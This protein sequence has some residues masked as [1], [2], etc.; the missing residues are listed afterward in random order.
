MRPSK[1]NAMPAENPRDNPVHYPADR[2]LRVWVQPRVVV[3]ALVLV[4]IPVAA[5]WVQVLAVG[6]PEIASSPPDHSAFDRPS[7][8]PSWVRVTHYVHFL[9]LVLLVRSGLSILMDH[10]RLYWNDHCTPGTEWMRFTPLAVP[11]ERVWTAKDDARYISPWLGLPGY[12]HSIG[13][14]RHWH[15]LSVLFWLGNGLLFVALLFWTNQ[16]KRLVPLSWQILPD[17]WPVFVY[18]ATCHL[19]VEPNGFVHFNPLQQLAYFGVVFLIAPLSLI[20][21]LAMSPALDNRFGWYP[22]LF[23]GRQCAR[24]IHF[25]LTLGYVAFL[26][27]HVMMVAMSGLVRNM[28]HIVLGTDDTPPLGLILGL[29]GIAGVMALCVVAHRVSWSVPRAVQHCVSGL[30]GPIGKLLFGKLKPCVRYDTADISPR[31][32]LNGK[33]PTSEDWLQLQ[34]GSFRG[35]RLR[36]YGLVENPVELSLAEMRTLGKQEQ[37]TM[38]HCIQGWSGIAAWGGLPLRTLIELVKPTPDAKVLVF[39]SFGEGLYGG[40]YY[41]TLTLANALYAQS[42]LAYE[43][44]FETLPV[45]YGAPLRLRAENQLG[46]KMVKWIKSVEFVASEKQIGKGHG[47][48]NEDDEYFPLV[49]NI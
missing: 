26:I 19:P 37:I 30:T 39:H 28:N 3:M 12:R 27:P 25:L 10:P 15:F 41:D 17:A 35:F 36:V 1:T 46:H 2:R 7:G 47:G 40:E 24:S 32:W 20:T 16:W 43:M 38:H 34:A 29:I 21:G 48:K 49:A 23:G 13:T 11:T 18:Y 45:L 42:L 22:K 5:A 8:F 44:N 9:F 14:A 33:V 4:L 6:L 31:L